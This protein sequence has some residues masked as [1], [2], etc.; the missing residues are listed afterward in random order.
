MHYRLFRNYRACECSQCGYEFEPL[1]NSCYQSKCDGC[2]HD[3]GEIGMGANCV[4][5]SRDDTGAIQITDEQESRW[6]DVLDVAEVEL[7]E[8]LVGWGRWRA[9]YR[10]TFEDG[11]TRLYAVDAGA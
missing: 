2:Y 8:Q 5:V 1:G 3:R 10:C 11:V 6:Q 9:L 7:V 4:R